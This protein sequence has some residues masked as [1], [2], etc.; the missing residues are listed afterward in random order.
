MKSTELF[1]KATLHYCKKD[2]VLD[3]EFAYNI[4]VGEILTIYQNHVAWLETS[5]EVIDDLNNL[6]LV[7]TEKSYLH[8]MIY[9]VVE[10]YQN[11][12]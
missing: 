4:R 1:T 9:I 10:L 2:Y 8:D 7:I 3:V 12:F 5:S 6:K 11:R